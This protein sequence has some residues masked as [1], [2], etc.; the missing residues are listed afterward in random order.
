ML[1]A[2][3]GPMNHPCMNGTHPAML[4]CH[5]C[6]SDVKSPCRFP[7]IPESNCCDDEACLRNDDKAVVHAARG[8]QHAQAGY[9]CDYCTKRQP[10]AFNEVN[11]CCKGHTNLSQR[12]L[13]QGACANHIGKRHATRLMSDAYGRGIVRRQV[14]YKSACIS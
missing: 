14:K 5:R 2:M 3:H 4:S 12:V 10:C 7:I 1:G 11:G 13:S 8:A 6:N 9:A